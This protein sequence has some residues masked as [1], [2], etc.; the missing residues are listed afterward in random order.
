VRLA[1]GDFAAAL[2]IADEDLGKMRATEMRCYLPAVLR[3]RGEALRGL[4]RTDEAMAALTEARA[5]AQRQGSRFGLWPV[6]ADL[7]ELE[8]ERGNVAEAAS[9]RR[10][11]RGVI[12]YIAD[13]ADDQGLREAFT[14]VPGVRA[15]LD[16]TR[17]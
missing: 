7:A 11:A 3:T 2:A 13:H 4:G 1:W 14:S 15:V 8:E 16:A 6:L 12:E 5:E 10:E 9:L 17:G